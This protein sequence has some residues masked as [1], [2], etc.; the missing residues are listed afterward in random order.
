M[1]C[2]QYSGPSLEGQDDQDSFRLQCDRARALHSPTASLWKWTAVRPRQ[3]GSDLIIPP[4][5]ARSIDAPKFQ[6][7]CSSVL[8]EIPYPAQQL[9]MWLP[10][11]KLIVAQHHLLWAIWFGRDYINELKAAYVSFKS[12][13]VALISVILP[14]ILGTL[15]SV[16]PH[17]WYTIALQGP[18]HPL[19]RCM[20]SPV[21]G[22]SSLW[23]KSW[24]KCNY[25]CCANFCG[26][27]SP[28]L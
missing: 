20:A 24:E 19:P 25:I 17:S 18:G 28:L 22:W 26:R 7:L 9:Q 8:K 23:E 16:S 13:G 27:W 21:N 2:H 4:D 5:R 10:I 1:W 3:M 12:L 6:R 15:V 14:S 11:V